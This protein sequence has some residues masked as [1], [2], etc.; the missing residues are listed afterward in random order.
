MFR[1]PKFRCR[2]GGQWLHPFLHV[3]P[4]NPRGRGIRPFNNCIVPEPPNAEIL[5][6]TLF[7]CDVS[8]VFLQRDGL[9]LKHNHDFAWDVGLR[10][11][12]RFVDRICVLAGRRPCDPSCITAHRCGCGCGCG[13]TLSFRRAREPCRPCDRRLEARNEFHLDVHQSLVDRTKRSYR[14]DGHNDEVAWNDVY[15]WHPKRCHV[16]PNVKDMLEG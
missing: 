8:R 13:S 4:R 12:T 2:R 10:V 1:A 3:A 11:C 15:G 5:S 6:S 14:L 16:K 7:Q 9:A